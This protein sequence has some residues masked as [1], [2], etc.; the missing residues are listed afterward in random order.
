MHPL[1]RVSSHALSSVGHGSFNRSGVTSNKSGV[2][3]DV[4]RQAPFQGSRMLNGEHGET[5]VTLSEE[6]SPY[7]ARDEATTWRREMPLR[8]NGESLYMRTWPRGC[9]WKK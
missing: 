1:H 4:A 7:E 8:M 3:D 2:R 5:R 6:Q 9:L